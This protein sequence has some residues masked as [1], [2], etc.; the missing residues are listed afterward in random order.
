MRIKHIEKPLK[1]T[2]AIYTDINKYHN[3]ETGSSNL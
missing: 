3:T 1:E 2:G